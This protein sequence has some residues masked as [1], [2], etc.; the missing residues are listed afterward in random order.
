MA[1]SCGASSTY[2]RAG[3]RGH[4]AGIESGRVDGLARLAEAALDDIV[5][6]GVEL[7]FE[8]VAHG[9]GSGGWLEDQAAVTNANHMS[10]GIGQGQE[11]EEDG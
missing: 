4:V 1:G 5:D 10:G 7:E 6:G 9:G 8:Q 11:A 3:R 2:A